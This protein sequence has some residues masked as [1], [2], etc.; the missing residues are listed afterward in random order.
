MASSGKV[1]VC[2]GMY[3][4]KGFANPLK[5][6]YSTS[7][8]QL[9]ELTNAA[10]TFG[11]AR[12]VNAVLAQF[13]PHPVKFRQVW[14]LARG[15][16]SL[17]AW[18][19][20]APEGFVALGM[21]CTT[22]EDA[23]DVRGMRCVPMTWVTPTKTQPQKIWDDTGAAGGRPGSIWQVNNLGLVVVVP[24][25]NAPTEVFYDLSASRFFLSS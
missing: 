18:Q 19:A 7:R 21:L 2:L 9:V 14:H 13:C 17:Y 24:G 20:Q 12:T 10:T 25:H 1:R 8:Y 15:A 6:S 22:T 3:A 4:S 5:S 16:K 11:K 23:P